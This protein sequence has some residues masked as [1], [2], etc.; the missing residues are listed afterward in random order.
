M[1]YAAMHKRDFNKF[2]TR[3]VLLS[4]ERAV[5]HTLSRQCLELYWQVTIET[6]QCKVI[7]MCIVDITTELS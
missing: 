5:N 1:F 4:T 7:R 2:G 3:N 6:I